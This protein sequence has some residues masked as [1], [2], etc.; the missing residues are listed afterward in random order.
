MSEVKLCKVLGCGKPKTPYNS[1][2]L[3]AVHYYRWTTY[4]SYDAPV[5][6]EKAL[7]CR[8]DDCE[9]P[10]QNPYS[11]CGMHRNRM[12]NHGSFDDRPPR[13]RKR[14]EYEEEITLD[15]V[16]KKCINH[17]DLKIH[18]VVKSKSKYVRVDGSI[19]EWDHYF[20]KE[21][22]N[23]YARKRNLMVEFGMTVEEYNN[24]LQIQN[25]RCAI[26]KLESKY[27][28]A[29]DHNHATNLNRGLLCINCNTAFGSFKESIEILQSAIE[30]AMTY[31]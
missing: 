5:K 29:V 25:N 31:Q 22:R 9:K 19:K 27:R 4:K 7:L 15:K 28:L 14:K 10:R 6:P 3:C 23:N 8:L 30:Y 12:S 24:L 2:L 16:V 21:C 13:K 17:G 11:L 18:Q 20:C 1:V 26:C